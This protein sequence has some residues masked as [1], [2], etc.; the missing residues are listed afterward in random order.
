[1]TWLFA[2]DFDWTLVD[3]NTDT[4]IFEKTIPSLLSEIRAQRAHVQWTDLMDNML[5]KAQKQGITLEQLKKALEIIPMNTHV[6]Q[7]FQKIKSKNGYIA[8]LSDANTFYI[9]TILEFYNLESYVDRI[10]TNPSYVDEFGKYRIRRHT[11][12]EHECQ[13]CPINLCKG[14]ELEKLV[15]EFNFEKVFY[16]GNYLFSIIKR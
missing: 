14:R 13:K 5:V 12:M 16:A 11:Q 15:R 6:V 10:I 9:K 1:M 2:F 3:E 4:W 7:L 8:I